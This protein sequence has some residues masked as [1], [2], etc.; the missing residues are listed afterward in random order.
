MHIPF[1]PSSPAIITLGRHIL[2]LCLFFVLLCALFFLSNTWIKYTHS[3]AH[4]SVLFSVSQ[5]HD[6][7]IHIQSHSRAD[8]LMTPG[9]AM[10]RG[11]H[12]ICMCVCASVRVYANIIE[13]TYFTWLANQIFYFFSSPNLPVR[14]GICILYLIHIFIIYCSSSYTVEIQDNP[15]FQKCK[16]IA[17][18]SFVIM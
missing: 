14:S 3:R 7:L 15:P 2:I 5:S 18:I 16:N 17:R 6:S 1:C 10:E 11:R 12:W 13:K 9:L 4:K 8:G